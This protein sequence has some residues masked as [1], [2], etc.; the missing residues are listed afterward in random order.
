MSPSN[1]EK[2]MRSILSLIRT[3]ALAVTLVAMSFP[4][5]ADGQVI[6][7]GV[8]KYGTLIVLQV[9]GSL[10]ARLKPLGITVE[11]RE[12]SSGPP[13]LEALAAGS[14]DFGT[15][16]EAPPVFAQAAGTP[17]VYVGVE[18][19]APKGEAILV[20]KDSAI[21]GLADLKGKRL[22]VARGSNAHYLAVASLLKAGL[23]PADVSWVFLAPAD[24]RAAFERG[25]VDAWSIWDPYLA[26]A[27]KESGGR[28]LT[29]G[30]GIANNHQF[31]L[32]SRDFVTKHPDILK[33]LYAELNA[34]DAWA[35]QHKP[36]VAELLSKHTGIAQAEIDVA[37]A[38]LGYGFGPVTPAVVAS[39]QN[40]ADSFFK[41]GL[42]P[43]QL[44]V[45]DIVLDVGS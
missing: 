29:D 37:L 20:P 26:V 24:A 39:Q 8:Q 35:A 19:A 12:F 40:I 36:E 9:K 45:A 15:T 4:A 22:A 5:F 16:G 21:Q 14:I 17:L 25:S 18:P 41:L 28:T 2:P 6:H 33:I 23:T 10:E 31:Y 1:S 32:A 43:R 34:S 42:I 27:Q 7:I 3:A 30:V 11:W 38:R 13:L 44:H